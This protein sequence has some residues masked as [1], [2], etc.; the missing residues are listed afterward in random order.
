M[1]LNRKGVSMLYVLMAL[2]CVGAM[3]SLVLSMAKKEKADS[4]LRYSSE[5]ARYGATSGLV[6]AVNEPLRT[7]RIKTLLEKWYRYWSDSKE[8]ASDEPKPE[9]KWLVGSK[10]EYFPDPT[11]GMRYRAR[12]V[13][14]DFHLKKVSGT[15]GTTTPKDSSYINVMVEC[16][17]IDK[18]GSRA[19]NV[20]FYKI[21]G[22][23]KED[24]D[25]SPKSALY[26]GGGMDE[27]NTQLTVTGIDNNTKGDTFFRG[28]GMI[29]MST[30][31]FGNSALGLIG[32]N[33]G[34]FRLRGTATTGTAS[35]EIG[36]IK[37]STFYG[38]AY[39]GADTTTITDN[40]PFLNVRKWFGDG[41]NKFFGKFGLESSIWL[42]STTNGI[43]FNDDVYLNGAIGN[44]TNGKWQF[45]EKYGT[46][47]NQDSD[48]PKLYYTNNSIYLTSNDKD[49]LFTTNPSKPT[50]GIS[51]M[52]SKPK[53][54]DGTEVDVEDGTT[55]TSMSKGTMLG[56]LGMD[57]KDPPAI[58][59]D[60]LVFKDKYHNFYDN[61]SW[62]NINGITAAQLN[63]AYQSAEKI[64][65]WMFIKFDQRFN[66]YSFNPTDNG[67]FDGKMVLVI[68]TNGNNPNTNLFKSG[69][70]SN[71][72][73]LVEDNT[74][75]DLGHANTFR[76]LIVK[77]GEKNAN[78]QYGLNI[79]AP[80]AATAGM[81]IQGA[82]YCVKNKQGR[83]GKFRLEGG[84]EE[85]NR[86]TIKFDQ[87]ILD[88]ITTDLEGV[89]IP[90]DDYD[91]SE[92]KLKLISNIN[93]VYAK[94]VSRLF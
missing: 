77:R 3:G 16:E 38:P 76:G 85:K 78:A 93:D 66:G 39:F 1:L 44:S 79:K 52:Y 83:T 31:I 65:G 91:L 9:D 32:K 54:T 50:D 17:S 55:Y 49:G 51:V 69:A 67:T 94:Q 84:D 82:V 88:E 21:F 41:A 36:T 74:S 28:S 2:V 45:N 89:I 71:C 22:F 62:G 81:T 19:K 73:I 33:G 27:I 12:I 68:A 75:V 40:P 47:G 58:D 56:L 86:I 72:L 53:K 6:L 7:D 70:N 23:E 34:E 11:T 14:V 57:V 90:P 37:S 43:E 61:L 80:D 5:L 4:S 46:T 10:T 48:F 63:A 18:S 92:P 60:T 30:H 20:G 87:R 35:T 24:A 29:N 25:F 15:S 26:L 64:N 42:E 13:N 8:Y 59:I